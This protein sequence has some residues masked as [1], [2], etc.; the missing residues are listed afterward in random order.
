M[1]LSDLLERCLYLLVC[2][3]TCLVHQVVQPLIIEQALRFGECAFHGVKSR[4]VSHVE[5]CFHVELS[6]NGLDFR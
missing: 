1:I 2:V 5:D 4:R 6:V 3:E